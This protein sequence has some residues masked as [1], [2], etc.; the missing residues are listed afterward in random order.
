MAE[1]IFLVGRSHRLVKVLAQNSTA[2]TLPQPQVVR[3]SAPG[4][5][6]DP[7]GVL[8]LGSLE[9]DVKNVGGDGMHC[10]NWIF[11]QPYCE[12]VP[13]TSFYL[14]VWGFTEAGVEN[15]VGAI[16]WVPFFIVQL[17]CVS[18]PIPGLANMPQAYLTDGENLC[19]T[20]IPTFGTL[21]SGMVSTPGGG[22]AA[23]AKI[24]LFGAKRLLVEF[25]PDPAM[26]APPNNTV[27][28]MN[29]LWRA[30]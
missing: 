16:V 10:P 13:G 22:F 29:A 5:G 17:F 18:A 23:F 3:Q 15:P 28:G 30:L 25:A 8:V 2:P 14:N 19:D 1:P 4:Q 12:G 24:E 6:V 21:G 7:P 27:P 11:L 9:S 20:L 26:A